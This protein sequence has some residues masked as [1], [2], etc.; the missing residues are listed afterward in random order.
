MKRVKKFRCVIV[1]MS[2][3]LSGCTYMYM[4]MYSHWIDS[5]SKQLLIEY[6]YTYTPVHSCIL[7]VSV[8]VH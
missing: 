6:E 2:V 3:A 1:L 8:M 5:I 4:Y 7:R